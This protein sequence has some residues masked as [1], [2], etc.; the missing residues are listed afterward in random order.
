MKDVKGMV[1][2]VLI[3]GTF[4]LQTSC[5]RN[6]YIDNQL[7]AGNIV[8]NKISSDTVYV[9]PDLTGNASEWFYWAMRVRGAQG[10]TLVFKFP[11]TCVG[12]RGAVVSL[13]LGKTF[14]Y[15]GDKT[16]DTFTWTF[17]PNDKEVY[18]YECHPYLPENW[19]R[20]ISTLDKNMYSLSVL[21][22]SRSGKEV[23]KASF[24]RL[25]GK[26][27]HRVVISVRHHCSETMASYV[28]EGIIQGFCAQDETGNW[29]R[30][31]VG[32]TVVPFVDYDGVVNGDQGKNRAPHDHN[33]DY[34]Q[35]LYPE[36]KALTNLFIEKH[37]EIILDLHCPY[38]SGG[39]NEQ[40]YNPLGDPETNPDNEAEARFT[41]I[42]DR[43]AKGLPYS[44]SNNIPF[45][46]SWNT[47][48]NYAA[49]MSSLQW[50]RFNAPG[51]KVCRCFEIPFANAG[52]TEVNPE[53][54]HVFG[55][56]LAVVIKEFFQN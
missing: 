39:V 53:S 9:E 5:E 8:V 51:A 4:C 33:R 49:G 6:I 30:E 34:V 37:A 3:L 41:E 38:I 47:N 40:L 44:S 11:R 52:G 17:G 1:F 36:T 35:F 28:L 14:F 15:S 26:E 23:P 21:C 19:D 27:S 2:I 31:N 25:D 46:T 54:C 20:F 22:Q 32:L 12:A 56:S 16:G 7:P 43:N 29:L 24:G 18:F 42:V 45:G 50:A 10:K 13:D 55:Q 48:K